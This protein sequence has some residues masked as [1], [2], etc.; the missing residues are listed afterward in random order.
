MR[1][2]RSPL[3]LRGLKYW[4]AGNYGQYSGRSPLGL[5]GLKY[6]SF[7]PLLL[8]RASQPTRAAWI[9][10]SHVAMYNTRFLKSQPTRAAWIEM[11]LFILRR[12]AK[13]SQPTRAAWIEILTC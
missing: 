12:T 1:A 9:E 6:R 7:C 13:Q 10:I 4:T 2:G 3:G 11:L 8:R 5:R